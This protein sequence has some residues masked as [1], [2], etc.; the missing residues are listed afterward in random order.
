[1][2]IL[3]LESLLRPPKRGAEV[4]IYQKE[5]AWGLLAVS[6]GRLKRSVEAHSN[7]AKIKATTQ[8]G[9]RLCQ[10]PCSSEWA[11]K[12]SQDGL[13]TAQRDPLKGQSLGSPMSMQGSQ[14]E[15]QLLIPSNSV[16][17]G[18][19]ESPDF[20]NEKHEGDKPWEFSLSQWLDLRGDCKAIQGQF[21]NFRKLCSLGHCDWRMLLALSERGQGYGMSS[22]TILC[23]D[24][25]TKYLQRW[26][27]NHLYFLSLEPDLFYK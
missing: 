11:L 2:P 24:S 1:M 21:G 19:K 12:P 20:D 26:T 13:R 23:P 3:D 10:H 22:V 4:I 18:V 25:F 15:A 7:R 14:S 16:H 6:L 9:I 5:M 17:G 8:A 27:I